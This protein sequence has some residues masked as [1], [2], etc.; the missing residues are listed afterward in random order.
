MV[1][2]K[3]FIIPA[4]LL[5]LS[6][7]SKGN[8]MQTLSAPSPEQELGASRSG[9]TLSI[10]VQQYKEGMPIFHTTLRNDS[11]ISYEYGEYYHIEILKN[12]E[13]YT[14]AHSDFV[15]YENPQFTNLGRLIAPAKV[16][17]QLF[18]V[19][20][21]GVTLMPGEYRL[22]KMFLKPVAPY[23]VVTLAVP[24]TVISAV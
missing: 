2:I 3:W 24:F 20:I 4:L 5:I 9:L 14:L 18:S 8:D 19:E 7:C 1:K 16:I 17:H 12:N 11:Q 6:A 21:I 10:S 22:V 13:W 15:F 23:Y